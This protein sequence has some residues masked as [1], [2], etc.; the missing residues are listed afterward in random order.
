MNNVKGPRC[1]FIHMHWDFSFCCCWYIGFSHTEDVKC[2]S[3]GFYSSVVLCCCNWLVL[4]L[5]W[6]VWWFYAADA[7]HFKAKAS[8]LLPLFTNN[9]WPSLACLDQRTHWVTLS[10]SDK[11]Q[12]AYF[13]IFYSKVYQSCQRQSWLL[14][15]KVVAPPMQQTDHM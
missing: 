5:H 6:P 14:Q 8:F 15:A 4:K 7:E 9:L 12:N 2:T 11:T 1:T 3:T 10:D 13:D